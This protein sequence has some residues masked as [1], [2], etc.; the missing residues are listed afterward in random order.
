MSETL[1]AVIF[2]YSVLLKN[3]AQILDQIRTLLE[4]LRAFGLRIV[5]FSTHERDIDDDLRSR[6]L[7]TPDLFL[8][9]RQLGVNKGSPRWVEKAAERLSLR[10]HQFAYVGDDELDWRTAINTPVFYMHAGWSGPVPNE[11]TAI[12]ARK[13]V[14]VF[15]F[16]THFLLPPPRWEYT[17]DALDGQVCLRSLADASILLPATTPTGSFRLQHVLSE[18]REVPVRGAKAQDLLMWHALSSLYL[19]GLIP[20]N[21]VMVAYPSSKPGSTSPVLE[22]FLRPVSRLFH[23]YYRDLLVRAAKAPDT[24]KERAQGRGGNV[25][26]LTQTNTVCLNPD[27]QNLVSENT[28]LVLDDFTTTGRSLEWARNLLYAAGASRVVLFTIGKYKYTHDVY[29]PRGEVVFPFTR[30][31]YTSDQF[32]MRTYQMHR[33]EGSQH[34]LKT[35][36]KHWAENKSYPV[37]QFL[38]ED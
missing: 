38:S 24:S 6:A 36:F 5:V 11:I 17:L 25:S 20:R 23:G 30:T 2:D 34:M 18:E 4:K 35:S 15:R 7:P 37:S 12:V 1:K 16:I 19:E 21:P 32:R 33:N 13:P 8:T 26:F 31:D 28:I 29:K 27:Y 10:T 9:K 3:E 14:N 22:P